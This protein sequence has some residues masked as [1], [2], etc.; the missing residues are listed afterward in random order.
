MLEETIDAIY[1]IK[2]PRGRPRKRPDKLH[3][4]K[5]YD[6]RKCR[7]ALRRRGITPRIARRGIESSERLGHHRWVSERT[8]SW[9]S[10]YRRLRIRYERRDDIHQAFLTL[11][12]ALICF[13][14][15]STEFC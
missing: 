15:L 4:D 2:R 10:R 1:P 8:F 12:C 7:Q 5:G 13:K 3:A 14:H 9:L 11:G 6:F